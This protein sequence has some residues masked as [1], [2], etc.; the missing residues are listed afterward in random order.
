MTRW[1]A[2]ML[3]K[4]AAAYVE[5]SEAAFEREVIAGNLPVP[6]KLGKQDHW[7][8]RELDDHL[9]RIAGRGGDWRKESK[10]YGTAA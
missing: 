7:H 8:R 2:M 10:L 5:L 6:V 9:D 1:P 3:R 4:T